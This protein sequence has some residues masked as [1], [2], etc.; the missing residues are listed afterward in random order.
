MVLAVRRSW[1]AL[2]MQM[3]LESWRHQRLTARTV[4]SQLQRFNALAAAPLQAHV[5]THALQD[6]F[7]AHT[8]LL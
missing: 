4:Q 7:R 1:T 3:V 5:L 6:A 8:R 2:V